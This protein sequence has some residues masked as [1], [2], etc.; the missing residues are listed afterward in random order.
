MWT[1]VCLIVLVALCCRPVSAE[2]P[3]V[4][5]MPAAPSSIAEFR[6]I[7]G[8]AGY[9][10]LDYATGEI[11]PGTMAFRTAAFHAE[12]V[13][14][15]TT[16]S[17]GSGY[18]TTPD[19]PNAVVGDSLWL[20]GDGLLDSL[21]FSIFNSDTSAGPLSR[22]DVEINFYDGYEMV[23]GTITLND[24]TIDPALN[25]GE[26]GLVTVQNLQPAGIDLPQNCMYTLLFTDVQGGADSIGQVLYN[27]PSVGESPDV[28][29]EGP[30]DISLGEHDAF[31]G[32]DP[33]A[34]FY[35]AV[36]V[37][38]P[39][40]L[41][42]LWDTGP[43]HTVL[44]FGVE[45]WVGY[46]SGET[47]DCGQRWAAMPFR[48]TEAGTVIKEFQARWFGSNGEADHVRYFIWN[49]TGLDAPTTPADV[50]LQGELG[51]VVAGER[52][53]RSAPFFQDFHTDDV[54]IAIPPGDYYLT[55]YGEG[56][57]LAWLGGCNFVPEEL[58]QEFF[59]RSCTF[60]DPGFQAYAPDDI[61]PG[62]GMTD[63]DDRWNLAYMFRGIVGLGDC[64]A[65]LDGDG[66]VNAA[67][68]AQLLGAWGPNPGH[69][70]D[71]DGDGNVDAADLAQLLGAWGDC[72]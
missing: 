13:Y 41:Q 71:F 25:P 70:A 22:A 66:N 68:L 17:T 35:F 3:D 11:T 45:A 31:F 52:D 33:V 6:P 34:N 63:P 29:Y 28:F 32:G 39:A 51:P 53:Y 50:F 48:I 19:D 55:I 1:R 27:P 36:R 14:D 24:L 47:S 56:T 7:R 57:H 37:E 38:N 72:E 59:W 8:V 62:P 54:N 61:Q 18:A 69:P 16:N 4:A 23:L 10:T 5:A 26:V 64:P 30:L 9:W 65:D 60:P 15:N 2:A 46:V 20:A 42:I 43:T 49:R 67:D 21:S 12:A 44:I 40:P 58:E